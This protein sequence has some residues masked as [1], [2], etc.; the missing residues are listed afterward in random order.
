M[1]SLPVDVVVFPPA[2][3]VPGPQF[4]RANTKSALTGFKVFDG[5]S[6]VVTT[7]LAVEHGV[8]TL[9]SAG[10]VAISGNGTGVLQLTG[11]LD[12]IN[13]VLTAAD[14]LAY[15]A[16]TNFLGAD[17]LT[18]TTSDDGFAGVL[19]QSDT[20]QVTINVGTLLDG[21]PGDD[22]FESLP[23]GGR[24]DA[25]SGNDTITFNFRLVDAT[26]TYDDNKLIVDGP[27]SHM[28]LS[29]FEKFV[30][31]DG[32]VDN[33]HGSRLVDDLYYYAHNH[34]VWNAHADAEQHY[35][36]FGWHEGRDPNA[37]FSTSS[38]LANYADVAAAGVNPLEHYATFGWTEG[39]V[40]SHAFDPAQYLAA[41]PDVAAAHVDPLLH[42]LQFGMAEGRTAFSEGVL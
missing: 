22:M 14:N 8:L 9:E 3:I 36:Q 4:V 19:P 38:Y 16:H 26:V 11:T 33:T 40:P 27:S 20:D 23:G 32:T 39:R 37:F 28:E 35:N 5:D 30:F 15:R 21:T 41:Y 42:Y 24:I 34:D 13:A 6:S 10:G 7:T 31:T 25:G 17:T 18:M 29:S 12:A 1:T 2:N